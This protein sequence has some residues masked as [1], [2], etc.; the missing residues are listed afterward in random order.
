M[1]VL[2]FNGPLRHYFSLYLQPSPAPTASAIGPSPRHWKFT[3]TIAP[4]DH[5]RKR[6]RPLPHSYPNKYDAP[7][8]EVYPAPSHHH[9]HTQDPLAWGHFIHVGHHLNKLGKRSLGHA[10]YQNIKHHSPV[11]YA[12]TS[13][14][15]SAIVQ[16][17]QTITTN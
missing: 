10:T 4:P 12:Q 3:S 1:V 15:A 7:A 11:K 13:P 6:S 16:P 9:H 17:N 8:L 14:F 5:P 2:G